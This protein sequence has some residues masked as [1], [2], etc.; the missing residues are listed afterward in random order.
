MAVVTIYLTLEGITGNLIEPLVFGKSVG[1]NPIAVLV[2]LMFWTWAWGP[3]GLALSIPM[4]LVIVTLGRHIPC[5]SMLEYL[6][7]DSRPLPPYIVF[8][9]RILSNDQGDAT[10]L[11]TTI[12]NARGFPTPSRKCS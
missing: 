1:M 7:G 10:K 5:F 9:E 2:A 11:F 8:F 12:A 3:V 6:L 4:S